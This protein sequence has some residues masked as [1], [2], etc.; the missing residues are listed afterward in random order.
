VRAR[1]TNAN[2]ESG[3]AGG[4]EGGRDSRI[5]GTTISTRSRWEILGTVCVCARAHARA[6]ASERANER[7]CVRVHDR[8]CISIKRPSPILPPSASSLLLFA[9][10][11]LVRPGRPAEYRAV[12]SELTVFFT[13]RVIESRTCNTLACHQG[14]VFLGL[15]GEGRQVVC[16]RERLML[17]I[18]LVQGDRDR[19]RTK[20]S[21]ALW[22]SARMVYALLASAGGRDKTRLRANIRVRSLIAF[23]LRPTRDRVHGAHGAKLRAT[24]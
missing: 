4:R 3:R 23:S 12:C 24:H 13:D 21:R 9:P 1:F 11:A 15:R 6:R 10:M 14:V 5:G 8:L 20:Y 22:H 2:G 19:P 16:L 18:A 7:V 17:H